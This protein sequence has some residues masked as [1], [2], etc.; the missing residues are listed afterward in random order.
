MALS[1]SII[2]QERMF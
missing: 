2:G 1:N